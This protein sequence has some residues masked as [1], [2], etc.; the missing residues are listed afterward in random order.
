MRDGGCYEG[1][2]KNGEMT[3][4]GQMRWPNGSTYKGDFFEGEKHG[5]GV[6]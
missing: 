5:K 3:G 1:D 2:F 4:S 6:F